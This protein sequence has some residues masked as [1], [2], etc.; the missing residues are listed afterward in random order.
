MDKSVKENCKDCQNFQQA[1]ITK[2][3]E[4]DVQPFE[5][6]SN[7]FQTVHMDIVGPLPPVKNLTYLYFSS[8]W[9]LLT[10]FDRATKWIEAVLLTEI[11]AKNTSL[12]HRYPDSEY[13]YISLPIEIVSLSC[14]QS[15]QR[16]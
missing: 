14:F 2:H 5:L 1:K 3:A 11:T 9:Y 16:S 12:K 7:H 6:P 4:G 15:Y 13:P 8:Y 10:M